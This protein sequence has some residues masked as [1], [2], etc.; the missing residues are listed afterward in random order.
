MKKFLTSTAILIL[1]VSLLSVSCNRPEPDNPTPVENRTTE[2]ALN[3]LASIGIESVVVNETEYLVCYY[4][5]GRLKTLSV[6][7]KD[8]ISF[9]DGLKY[10]T[11]IL[12]DGKQFTLQYTDWID[13]ELDTDLVLFNARCDSRVINYT[14]K[15]SSQD[16]IVVIIKGGADLIKPEVKRSPDRKSGQIIL[17]PLVNGPFIVEDLNI[18]ITNGRKNVAIP[19]KALRR[20]F[21]FADGD[22][23]KDFEFPEYGRIAPLPLT[24]IE[25]ETEIIVSD[26][27]SDWLRAEVKEGQ[28]DSE[29]C[30]LLN[31]I[32]E[33]NRGAEPR[34]GTVILKDKETND[35][36]VVNI[37]QKGAQMPG[38]FTEALKAFYDALDGPNWYLW[39]D[40]DTRVINWFSN[41]PMAEWFSIEP[42]KSMTSDIFGRKKN[43]YY[44]TNDLWSMKFEANGLKGTIP[45]AFWDQSY[46]F[47]EISIT[48]A[49]LDESIL[50][51]K[52]W[53]KDLEILEFKHTYIK[54]ELTPDIAKATNLREL[55]ISRSLLTG[56][57]PEVIGTLKNLHIMN[58]YAGYLTGYIPDSIR[59]L[60]E[61]EILNVSSNID[62]E[63]TIPDGVYDL[64]GLR[65]LDVSYTKIGGILPKKI[66]NLTNL[67]NLDISYCEFYGDIPEEIGM[68]KNLA[69]YY[70]MNYFEKQ[71]EFE[72][73]HPY[74]TGSKNVWS[75]D[76]ILPETS[77]GYAQRKLRSGR[78]EDFILRNEEKDVISKDLVIYSSVILSPDIT[79]YKDIIFEL[80]LWARIR[81]GIKN[82]TTFRLEDLKHP[83]YPYAD[84]LQYPADEYYYDGKDWRHP[85]LKYPAREYCRND[86]GEWVHD[87]S[88]PW[89]KEYIPEN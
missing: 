36:L 62:M 66:K 37:V 60:K 69:F 89:D 49:Y 72:R 67:N 8:I 15:D 50:S 65:T 52:V 59:N 40:G 14:V 88:C 77:D 4:E 12:K 80:P 84:D 58:F 28:Y 85:Q 63:G 29:D 39:Y 70:R 18:I 7:A 25:N 41:D 42:K 9:E 73:Y 35:S 86:A 45:E 81:Y 74:F 43:Y 76:N 2:N 44:G 75:L 23:I 24:D 13:V 57:I 17:T 61:L 31:A 82:W 87:P 21:A 68:I 19:V 27:C 51:P 47:Y 83:V 3:A 32:M 10:V 11:F 6:P 33:D 16:S 30:L 55:E 38:S 48:D 5:N 54:G 1:S 78:P 64:T 22:T 53:H 79:T 56:N 26:G 71:P 46:K 20:N 34:T